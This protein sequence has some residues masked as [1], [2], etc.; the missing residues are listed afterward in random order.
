MAAAWWS[1]SFIG[2]GRHKQTA[3]GRTVSAL[4]CCECATGMHLCVLCVL[5]EQG[6]LCR[7]CPAGCGPGMLLS[8]ARHKAVV[9][10]ERTSTVGGHT[11][12]PTRANCALSQT[13]QH[14]RDS[15]RTRWMASCLSM[16]SHN[17]HPFQDH[18]KLEEK[19]HF[20]CKNNWKCC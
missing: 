15:F 9:S 11:T 7:S 8:L 3:A 14:I 18:S 20:G 19:I 5:W 4:I 13:F 1:D 17:D 2:T 6:H 12:S 10:P 16:V